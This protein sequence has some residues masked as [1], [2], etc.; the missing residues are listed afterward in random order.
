M[1][2]YTKVYCMLNAHDHVIC[3]Y[4][5]A[6]LHAKGN[7]SSTN[8]SIAWLCEIAFGFHGC[9]HTHITCVFMF[10]MLFIRFNDV[11]YRTFNNVNR[12]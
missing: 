6:V 1:K 8:S 9:Q 3:I 10:L 12:T 4:Y 7:R 2:S 5:M 11:N